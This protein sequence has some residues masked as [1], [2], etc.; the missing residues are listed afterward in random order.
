MAS[1]WKGRAPWSTSS[2]SSAGGGT[3]GA[4]VPDLPGCVAVGETKEEAMELIR[5]AI[6]MHLE[7]M[8]E[9]GLPIPDPTSTVESIKV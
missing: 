7:A 5:T 4:Y 2:F 3:Y 1:S 6:S 9:E 8:R